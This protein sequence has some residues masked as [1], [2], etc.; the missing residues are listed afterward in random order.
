MVS[1]GFL[2]NK[3][4][5]KPFVIF[6]LSFL[7]TGILE[8]VCGFL[9]LKILKMRLWDYTGYF[10]NINGFV[11]L[12]SAFC[13]GIGG[14]LVIYLIYPLIKKIYEKINKRFLKVIL[15]IISLIFLSDV[16]ATILK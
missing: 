10:L 5:K 6:A 1:H 3:Y 16:I 11:C 2:L 7:L 4:R 12:L 8:Y 13:F 14:L 9:L 15:S